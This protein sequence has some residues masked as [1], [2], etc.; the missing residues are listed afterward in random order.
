MN[1]NSVIK[2]NRTLPWFLFIF[3]WVSMTLYSFS[4]L[5]LNLTLYPYPGIRALIQAIQWIGYWN[6]P[7]SAW[8]LGII[9]FGLIGSYVWILNRSAKPSRIGW[10]VLIGL[11]ITSGF[12]AY[13]VF[14]H[15][16]FN[17]LFNAKML[18]VYG[19]DPHIYTAIEFPNDPWVRFMH[20]V[21]TPAPYAYGWTYL[22]LFPV[23]FTIKKF[24][25]SLFAM[26]A[27]V[28]GFWM[29]EAWLIKLITDIRIGNGYTDKGEAEW[30]R[31]LVFVLNPLILVETL[32]VGHNDSVMMAL[33]LLSIWFVYRYDQN[34][35]PYQL[36]LALM[37]WAAS[38]SIKYASVV[39]LPLFWLR[40]KIDFFAWGG[41][42]LL[43][44]LISRPGQ[45]HS[46]YLHW[47]MVMLLL[48]PQRWARRL[49]LAL[50]IGGLLRYIPYVYYG[51]WDQPVIWMR[52]V[53]LVIPILLF[54]GSMM[55]QKM[56]NN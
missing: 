14:S 6:R 7:I 12:L 8:L 22:S 37:A 54:I 11:L 43:L 30:K 28:I 52:W 23:W 10:F 24:T 17:Y 44:V 33:V 25:L 5:D 56:T 41:V 2:Q 15:D 9:L 39:L 26:K 36:G 3:F 46:W 32:I 34:R 27:L 19:K 48:S 16:I 47:G 55:K 51:H 35:K 29:V 20:N 1:F 50:T 40:K 13:P 21:H 45:L 42:I 4:Q 31:T 49:V 53:I 38:V 18:L